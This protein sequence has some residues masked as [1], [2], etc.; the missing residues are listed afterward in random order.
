[1]TVVERLRTHGRPGVET[2]LEPYVRA[3][4]FDEYEVHLVASVARLAPDLDDGVGLALALAARAARVGHVCTGLRPEALPV[5]TADG[6]EPATEALSW[7]AA[8]EWERR[9]RSSTLVAE[10]IDADLVPR[11]PL[12][13]DL[14]RLYLRRLWRD[15]IRVA[16]EI[17]RR[18]VDPPSAQRTVE[19]LLDRLFGARTLGAP[20]PEAGTGADP[21]STAD[22]RQRL[23]VRRGLFEPVSIIAGGPGTGKTHTVARLLA[24]ASLMSA[25]EGRRPT[26]ALAAPTGKAANRMS[27][28]VAVAVA[29]LRAAGVLDDETATALAATPA[30]TLHRLL[31]ARGEGTFRH[32]RRDPLPHDLVIVDETSMV[33]LPLLAD[34]MTALRPEARLVLVGDPSQLTS[35]EAGTVM[36]DLVGPSGGED[37]TGGRATTGGTWPGTDGRPL[38]G[39]VTLL[40][41]VHRYHT[42][43]GIA[44][45]ASAVRQGH[46]DEAVE[47]LAAGG[48]VRWV[49]PDDPAGLEA[50]RAEVVT[51]GLAMV[52]AARAADAEGALE[53]SARTKVLCA[54]RRGPMG[55][56]AWT[57]Q[58]R[59]GV[60]GQTVAPVRGRG[61]WYPGRPV[62]VTAND[63]INR[64]LNG[65]VGVV[66]NGNGQLQVALREGE[67]VRRLG[68]AQ[69]EQFDEWWAM[70]IHKSQGSEFVHAV[71]VLPDAA[72]PILSRELL[73]TGVTRARERLTVIASEGALR[74]AVERPVSRAS[75]L[76]ERLWGSPPP[77]TAVGSAEGS[78]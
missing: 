1:M 16:E 26:V 55:S 58:V 75:G 69:L 60:L 42:E 9:L 24:A 30:V 47:G 65:D 4:L 11:R 45:L 54:V 17:R 50:V 49:R 48:D 5:V 15:E 72:S 28:A 22:D 70:T 51:D 62:M 44:A 35:I 29:G 18:C 40:D 78:G 71:V 39:R 73:Y 43:S 13:W 8:K 46:P 27:E 64:L 14:G 12:V 19:G 41:R 6:E 59:S 53:L 61:R 37:R 38:R 21:V 2:A 10:A 20:S 66:V 57:E 31:G 23:A 52:A 67:G 3:G 33:S 77:A 7:P 56:A 32:D 25:G 74:A 63:P 36:S 76:A 68:L 34:L